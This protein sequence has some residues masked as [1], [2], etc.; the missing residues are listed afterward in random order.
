MRKK[1]EEF[2]HEFVENR[3]I[4]GMTTEMY[5]TY[6][7]LIMDAESDEDIKEIKQ[8][9]MIDISIDNDSNR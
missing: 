2:L 4:I 5:L 6:Y 9:L 8:Q 3:H 1:Q 7:E